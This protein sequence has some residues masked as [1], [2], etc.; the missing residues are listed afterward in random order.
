[1]SFSLYFWEEIVFYD[2]SKIFLAEAN[3][4]DVSIKI[5]VYPILYV[6]YIRN[7]L[8]KKKDEIRKHIKLIKPTTTKH[9]TKQKK[10]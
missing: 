6:S 7:A 3:V 4:C 2:K 5:I 1:M 8:T 9:K 10:G